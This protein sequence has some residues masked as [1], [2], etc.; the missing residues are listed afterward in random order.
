MLSAKRG[1][2]KAES[3]PACKSVEVPF[4]AARLKTA[5]GRDATA[6]LSADRVFALLAKIAG[7]TAEFVIL[8]FVPFTGA[9]F[10]FFGGYYERTVKRNTR[11]S[12]SGS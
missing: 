2:V 7:G 10:I 8:R 11:N 6:A 1:S 4:R 12:F 9:K 5:V 3:R